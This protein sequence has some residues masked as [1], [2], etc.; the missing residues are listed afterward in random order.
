MKGGSSV[1]ASEELNT[2]KYLPSNKVEEDNNFF[3]PMHPTLIMPPPLRNFGLHE[4]PAVDD[5]FLIFVLIT[6]LLKAAPWSMTL[7]SPSDAKM[8]VDA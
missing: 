3:L 5:Y 1:E 2:K 6:W 8:N 7:F 4:A